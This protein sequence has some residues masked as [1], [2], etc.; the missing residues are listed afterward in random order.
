MDYC[1]F[2]LEMDG[3]SL[4][5]EDDKSEAS[6]PNQMN[7][8]ESTDDDESQDKVNDSQIL[9]VGRAAYG[10]SIITP[11][12]IPVDMMQKEASNVD[13]RPHCK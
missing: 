2:S 8:D 3:Q 9:Q 13:E 10:R 1:Q 5:N 11:V 4:S 6:K 7:D 12:N